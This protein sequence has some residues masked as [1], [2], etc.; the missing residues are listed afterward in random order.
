MKTKLTYQQTRMARTLGLNHAQARIV[1][2]VSNRGRLL[3][4]VAG[5]DGSSGYTTEDDAGADAELR[6]MV[7]D[8]LASFRRAG[9]D[10]EIARK[11][12]KR[13]LRDAGASD[14]TVA[15]LMADEDLDDADLDAG[16]V[17]TD[18]D[19]YDGAQAEQEMRR[20]QDQT[21]GDSS[22]TEDA[23]RRRRE[24]H[25]AS[26]CC[27]DAEAKR[28]AE[29]DDDALADELAALDDDED[30]EEEGDTEEG[31]EEDADEGA[32][33]ARGRVELSRSIGDVVQPLTPRGAA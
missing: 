11:A 21:M 26:G 16:D 12:I 8:Q 27:S 3:T 33:L 19:A 15:R 25:L 4:N 24:K 2:H 6:K 1:A 22:D 10:E 31:D 5:L 29:L 13:A 14:E 7:K 17:D 30:D 20:L 9:T 23:Q 28:L 32:E 18:T